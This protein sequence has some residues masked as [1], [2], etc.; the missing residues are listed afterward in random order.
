MGLM[1]IT[2]LVSFTSPGSYHHDGLGR[3]RIS[4]RRCLSLDPLEADPETRIQVQAA[5]LGDTGNTSR[6]IEDEEWREEKAGCIV[7]PTTRTG[8]W[9]L[10]LWKNPRSC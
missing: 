8:D 6:R 7:Q 5:D 4:H 2:Y 1:G 9:S 10:I 3:R